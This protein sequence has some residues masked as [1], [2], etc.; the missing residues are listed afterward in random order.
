MESRRTLE[1]LPSAGRIT[2]ATCSRSG[3]CNP[4]LEEAKPRG[5][6]EDFSRSLG[7]G[8]GEQ[9]DRACLFHRQ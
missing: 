5:L 2:V 4:R 3:L 7:S 1:S 9:L 6:E 8:G